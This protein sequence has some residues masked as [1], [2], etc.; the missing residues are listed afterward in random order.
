[1]LREAGSEHLRSIK[2]KLIAMYLG[3]VLIVMIVSGTY[4]LLSLRNIEID[5]SRAQLE[6][7]A[8]K[9]NEQVIESVEERNFQE[10]LMETVT[11]AVG[12]QGNILD[13]NGDTIASTT[14]LK[15]PYPEYTDQ[16]II[17]AMNGMTSF[18]SGKRSTDSLGLLKEWMSYAMPAQNRES[19]QSYIV[20]TRLD[21]GDMQASL[22]QTT[23][24]IVA[25]VA[26]ALFLAVIM[27]YVFAQT[28]TGPILALTKGAKSLAE[29]SLNQSLKVRSGDEIGQLT[30]SF[31]YMASELTKNMSEISREKNR[32]EIILHNMSDGVISFNRDGDLML[33]NAAAENMLGVEE[34][35][36]DFSEFVRAYDV[37]SAVYLDMGSEPSRK[38]IFPVG[39]QFIN[40]N[41]SPYYDTAGH[42]EGVVVVLQDITEQKKLDDMR[43]EFVANVSHELRTPLTTVKSYTETLMEG[44]ID[45]KEIAMDFLGII[46]SE[47]DRMAFLVRDLLQLTRFDNKQVRLDITEIEMNEFLS[48]TVRQNK[49]H[50]DAKNQELTFEPYAHDVVIYGD[51]DRV[52]QVVNNIVTN[53]V[54]YSLDQAKIHIYIGEDAQ[55][56]KISVKDTGMGISREDLPRIFERFYRVDKARSRAMGGTGLGLAIAKEIMESHGGRLTAESEYGKG[57]IMTMWFPKERPELHY[58]EDEA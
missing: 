55:Y 34:M 9:I 27:G 12:I 50:A 32:L 45:D 42:I 31:N 46:D 35:T 52:G 26:I 49:I 38:V 17:A 37:N 33:A 3:L 6:S 19:G 15:A 39:K 5:K 48:L 24:T 54:K 2:W 44:A 20:Y 22:N 28:L 36:M 13:S 56:Y 40:A 7:Y 29:G 30:S 1:M 47:A 16:A 18:S 41:F 43:K 14:E 53:A 51:R 21:A 8:E 10:K 23:Q 4:I 11:N 57:T 25:A 58:E